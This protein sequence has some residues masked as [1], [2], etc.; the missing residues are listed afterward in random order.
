MAFW[1]L[2]DFWERKCSKNVS[3]DLI[4]WAGKHPTPYDFFFTFNDI[5]GENLDWFWQPWFFG[6]QYLDLAIMKVESVGK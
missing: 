4:R 6:F 1:T 5:S 3:M 2:Q